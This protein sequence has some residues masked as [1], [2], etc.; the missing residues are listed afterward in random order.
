[1]TVIYSFSKEDIT[2]VVEKYVELL[3]ELMVDRSLRIVNTKVVHK[4]K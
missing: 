4:N 2:V 3:K 1:M